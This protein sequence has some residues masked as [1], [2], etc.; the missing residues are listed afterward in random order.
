M[1]K[2][3]L[4]PAICLERLKRIDDD[5]LTYELRHPD[6]QGRTHVVLTSRTQ[7]TTIDRPE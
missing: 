2:Y 4:R 1:F 7:C 5:T 3:M 6:R